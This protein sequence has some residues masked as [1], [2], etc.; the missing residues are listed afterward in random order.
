MT[1]IS[2]TAIRQL[3]SKRDVA[4]FF[5]D[6]SAEKLTLENA[7]IEYP[8]EDFLAEWNASFFFFHAPEWLAYAELAKATPPQI[9]LIRDGAVVFRSNFRYSGFCFTSANSWS[10][11]HDQALSNR[12]IVWAALDLVA[13]F[14]EKN[15]RASSRPD[16]VEIGGQ[17]PSHRLGLSHGRTEVS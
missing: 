10:V 17:N 11:N 3:S 14:I 4:V 16:V 9:Q 2:M 1:T 7:A 12:R 13:I 15:A 5:G 6:A 8:P